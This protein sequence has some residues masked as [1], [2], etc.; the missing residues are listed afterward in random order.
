MLVLL[1]NEEGMIQTSLLESSQKKSQSHLRVYWQE[2]L[3]ADKVWLP[4]GQNISKM[5]WKFSLKNPSS[6]L[7]T[8]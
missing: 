1:R 5:D 7:H 6:A 2:A 3:A 8:F 4:T